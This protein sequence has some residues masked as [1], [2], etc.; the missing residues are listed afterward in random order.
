M[1]KKRLCSLLLAG[2]MA[3]SL[4]ACGSDGG[5]KRYDRRTRARH[6]ASF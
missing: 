2:T 3:F 5:R 6:D 4:A 1:N